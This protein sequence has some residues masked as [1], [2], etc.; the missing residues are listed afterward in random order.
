MSVLCGVRCVC[1]LHFVCCVYHT[2]VWAVLHDNFGQCSCLCYVMYVVCVVCVVSVVWLCWLVSVHVCV[3]SRVLFVWLCVCSA[4]LFVWPVFMSVFCCV[5]CLHFVCCVYH[6]IVWAVLHDNFG[7]CSCLCYVMYVVC[8][9]CV[10][11]V[12][13]LCW[14]VS[15][16]VCVMSRVLFVWLCVCSATLFVWPVFM[17]VFCCVCCLHFVCCVYHTIVWSV[18]HGYF[19][20]C[21]CLRYVM[22]VAC[23]VCVVSVVWLCWLVSVHVCVMSRV[24]F[25]WLCVLCH[26]THTITQTTHVT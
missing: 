25:V 2:I 22:Y 5:C 17:S 12:V 20:Q 16:H 15:V 4:T 23:V 14:L 10:V 7:Q 6:T 13:W 9:V 3:M 1:C 19:G 11:S 8:V 24:L 26:I 21:S 18:L